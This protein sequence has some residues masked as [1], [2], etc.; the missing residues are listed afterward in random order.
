LAKVPVA[1]YLDA[2]A[3][4][5]G[6]NSATFDCLVVEKSINPISSIDEG[7]WDGHVFKDSQWQEREKFSEE[8]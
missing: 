7:E 2:L 3:M 8:M 4:N 6:G 5:G 1:N